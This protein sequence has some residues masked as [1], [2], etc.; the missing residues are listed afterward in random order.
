MLSFFRRGEADPQTAM[1]QRAEKYQA[2]AARDKMLE[3]LGNLL[4]QCIRSQGTNTEEALVTD[5]RSQMKE[6]KVTPQ[7][8]RKGALAVGLTEQ[9]ITQA[10]LSLKLE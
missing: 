2:E 10:M 7:D 3:R 4:N 1:H 6:Q 8:L 9:E 5:L